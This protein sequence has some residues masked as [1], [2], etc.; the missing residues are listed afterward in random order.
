MLT[1]LCDI[2]GFAEVEENAQ[3]S[4]LMLDIGDISLDR[5]FEPEN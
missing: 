5:T 3:K 1:V 2:I 4:S